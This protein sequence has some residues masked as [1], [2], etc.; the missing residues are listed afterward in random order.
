M[1]QPQMINRTA[2]ASSTILRSRTQLTAI[3]FKPNILIENNIQR[4]AMT[5]IKTFNTKKATQPVGPY[6]CQQVY[7]YLYERGGLLTEYPQSQAIVAGPHIF[8]SGQLPAAA[9]GN[10]V[11]GSIADKT[12]ACCE[13]LKNILEDAGSSL[14]RVVKVLP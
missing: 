12:T 13:N 8:V 4:R 11:E 9:S 1:L 5:E 6:V 3:R 7:F 14:S 2:R 10:L